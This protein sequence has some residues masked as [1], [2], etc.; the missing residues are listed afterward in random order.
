MFE[1]HMY[2]NDA[3]EGQ[4]FAELVTDIEKWRVRSA[5]KAGEPKSLQIPPIGS[6]IVFPATGTPL[7]ASSRVESITNAIE[8]AA[9]EPTPVTVAAPPEPQNA[10]D[11]QV[12]DAALESAVRGFLNAKGMVATVA[13]LAEFDVKRAGQIPPERRAE[14]IKYIEGLA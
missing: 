14:F 9:A 10:P 6:P 1:V 7:Q 2:L 11:A 5:P 12:D 4:M 13:A 3:T 8:T